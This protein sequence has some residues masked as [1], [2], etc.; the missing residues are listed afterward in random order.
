MGSK[1]ISRFSSFKIVF[2]YAVFS[3]L[4][5]YTS[6]YFLAAVV[7]DI[8]LLTKLQTLKGLVFIL[9]TSLFLYVLVK[10]NIDKAIAHYQ[11]VIDLQQQ[12]DEQVQKSQEAYLSLFNQSPLPMV[13]F[14]NETLQFLL[15]NDAACTNYGYTKEEYATMTLKDIRP[16]E[17]IPVL[18]KNIALSSKSGIMSY[19]DI[20]RH[21]KKNGEII[22]VKIKTT[23]V[24]FEG[25]QVRLA[26]PFDITKEMDI[27]SKLIAS[28]A[29]FQVASEIAG[30]GYWTH[31]LINH[32]IQWSEEL[33]KIYE[34]DPL[35]FP[36]TIESIKSCFHPEDHNYFNPKVLNDFEDIPIKENENRIITPEGKVK[37]I[38]ERI[39]V[40]KNEEGKVTKLEGVTLDITKRKL[41]EQ[42]LQESEERFK[43]LAKATAEAIIDWDIKNDKVVWGDGFQTLFGYDLEVYD[44]YLW[45]K[46]IHPEDRGQV[47]HDLN[48][49]IEDPTKQYFIAQFRFL[50]ANRDI[51]F[52]QHKGVF[53]RDSKG[54]AIRAYAAMIDLTESLERMNQIELQDKALKEISWTQSH[55]VRAP[56]ANLLG[57]IYLL[58][59]NIETGLS[60]KEIID[61]IGASA[62]RLDEII[63]DIVSKTN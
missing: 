40:S 15:V 25:K 50:K 23:F 53:I 29:R 44:N 37:W 22:Q 26:L 46:N 2:F 27:Q 49:T 28:N 57:F 43:I 34:V 35:Y 3:A 47:L 14:D 9:F 36:L 31:D 13:L 30:L 54:V 51:A 6:D 56:L 62:K 33:Y 12:S 11:H 8:G 39:F 4:Y 52:V 45:S 63:R 55:V 21:R 7:P 24:T 41:H 42:A 38:F 32:H 17:D 48:T 18:E 61:H 59:E 1:N 19:D 20:I 60:D 16:I 58:E 5:I 10:K